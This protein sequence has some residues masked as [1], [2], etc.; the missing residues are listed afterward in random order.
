ML[1]VYYIYAYYMHGDAVEGWTTIV[2]LQLF[3]GG[4]MLLS[5]GVI[6]E[7]IGRSY[8]SINRKPQ[9]LIRETIND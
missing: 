1:G 6:G 9:F 8:L 2:T 7:Y 5:L 4:A 3:I